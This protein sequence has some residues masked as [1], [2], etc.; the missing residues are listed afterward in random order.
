M[1]AHVAS[2]ELP[3]LFVISI[4]ATVIGWTIQHGIL[5]LFRPGYVRFAEPY[6]VVPLESS[7]A[8][9]HGIWI[10]IVSFL[11][12]IQMPICYVGCLIIANTWIYISLYIRNT[13][14]LENIKSVCI[15]LHQFVNTCNLHLFRL[16]KCAICRTIP[17]KMP[18]GV[19]SVVTDFKS[20]LNFKVNFSKIWFS[21][22]SIFVDM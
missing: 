6:H 5:F 16:L 22:T 14:I 21:Q 2:W 19:W 18:P 8:P 7:A 3:S 9:K 4:T 11:N 20:L 12:T 10:N 15:F 13:A 1:I 17:V